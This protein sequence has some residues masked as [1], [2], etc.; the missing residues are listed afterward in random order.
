MISLDID[1]RRS[2]AV[3]LEAGGVSCK[4]LL[5]FGNA[6]FWFVQRFV[7]KVTRKHV[8]SEVKVRCTG[9]AGTTGAF[10]HWYKY[11]LSIRPL[12]NR[13][14]P[15]WSS[16]SAVEVSDCFVS[17]LE[18][19]M[20]DFQVQ[21]YHLA[22]WCVMLIIFFFFSFDLSH[23]SVFLTSWCHSAS[24]C[25]RLT[26]GKNYSFKSSLERSW[27]KQY[28]S[29]QS[30]TKQQCRQSSMENVYFVL[31]QTGFRTH[32]V[33]G[34]TYRGSPGVASATRHKKASSCCKVG[35]GLCC[36]FI[37]EYNDVVKLSKSFWGLHQVNSKMKTL[38][39]E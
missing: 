12:N 24:F 39:N 1:L 35:H 17:S 34:P 16:G 2:W 36:W 23:F 22:T 20:P 18:R 33:E 9:T 32:C 21:K 6:F 28:S 11:C 25:S 13:V 31:P 15:H 26:K 3:W 19:P 14:L 30:R 7:M 37:C 8:N 29:F 4:A 5:Y 38:L 27:R 10:P